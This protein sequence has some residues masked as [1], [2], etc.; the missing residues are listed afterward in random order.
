MGDWR[1]FVGRFL[2]NNSLIVVGR[3]KKDMTFKEFL[4]EQFNYVMTHGKL[5]SGF[6][7]R[8]DIVD[9]Q[10]QQ[11]PRRMSANEQ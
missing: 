9:Y 4:G 11:R 7:D 8:A 10:R 1:G 5:D 6:W 3:F 2:I